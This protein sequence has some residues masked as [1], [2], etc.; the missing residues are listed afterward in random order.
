MWGTRFSHQTSPIRSCADALQQLIR[1]TV[2]A[3]MNDFKGKKT[4]LK[5]RLKRVLNLI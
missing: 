5:K 3:Q 1:E 4:V 2:I